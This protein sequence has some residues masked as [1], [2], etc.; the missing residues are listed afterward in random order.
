[1]A[2]L[3][4]GFEAIFR[5]QLPGLLGFEPSFAGWVSDGNGTY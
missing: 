1:M 4:S 5:D 3:G 2:R